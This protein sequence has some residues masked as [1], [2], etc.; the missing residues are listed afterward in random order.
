M[1]DYL[2]LKN[3]L[4]DFVNL[5]ILNRRVGLIPRASLEVAFLTPDRAR[6]FC[7]RKGNKMEWYRFNIDAYRLD[8][9]HLDP[10]QDGCYRRLIDHYMQSKQPLPNNDHA[11]ARII[12]I[13][14]AEWMSKAEAILKPFLKLKKD[15]FL[16]I[17]KCDEELDFQRN[18]K[19]TLQKAAKKAINSRW[20][21]HKEN[22][23]LNTDRIRK[24][25]D[26]H[27][28]LKTL[29]SRRI[30]SDLELIPVITDRP[31]LEATAARGAVAKVDLAHVDVG[32]EIARITGW[33][34]SP[35]WFGDF[36]RVEV[37]L[38][39]GFDPK[40]DIY[41][42][43][44]KLMAKRS[45]PPQSLAYFESAIADAHAARIKPLAK[46]NPSHDLRPKLSRSDQA[47]AAIARAAARLQAEDDQ[48][49]I[50]ITGPDP[51]IV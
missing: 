32:Q 6:A 42:T 14:H 37:W 2:N 40:K 38:K 10:Y 23:D 26:N 33:D 21:K 43:V 3:A 7:H 1:A 17:K 51:S 45:K 9:L 44:K 24:P 46:G 5:R 41:P 15:G 34:R 48:Q 18:Q 25:Y 16:H 11:L 29:E 12:G 27:T 36:G 39:N 8:T 50:A 31:P 4:P 22:K 49:P 13:S 20:Q 47:D 35:N 30:D 19:H 28:R